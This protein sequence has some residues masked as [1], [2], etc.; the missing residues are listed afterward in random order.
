MILAPSILSLDYSRFNE[1]MEVLN[2]KCR[3]LH[4]DVMDG[5][6]VPNLSFGPDI[7]KC[8]RKNTSLFLDVHLMVKDPKFFT[9]VFAENGADG[10]TFHYEALEN[11]EECLEL[12]DYIHSFYLK[13]GVSIKPGTDPEAIKELLP[14]LDLVLVMSV[15]PGFGGQSF[16]E[17][18][19]DKVKWLKEY[20]D[21]MLIYYFAIKYE[22][23]KAKI[24][25]KNYK[26]IDCFT[27]TTFKVKDNNLIINN[28]KDDYT[29]LVC[30]LKRREN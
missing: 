12:I 26:P 18:S 29:T 11:K 10:I 6:F 15:E 9:K 3:W 24:D 13:A 2:R 21:E 8:F 22:K 20:K 23:S 14:Y 7:L 25:I 30:Y 4:F 27:N 28:Y 1:S 17:N 5:N 16:M 19:L